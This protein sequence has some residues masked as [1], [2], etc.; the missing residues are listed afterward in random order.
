M[1]GPLILM[2]TICVT[3]AILMQAHPDRVMRTVGTTA[4][5]VTIV[6]PLALELLGILPSSY[7]FEGGKLVTLPQLNELPELPTYAFLAV[8]NLGAALAPALFVSRLRAELERSQERELVR[9]WRFRRL[10]EE[11]IR[12][13][14]R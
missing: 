9:A 7:L 12:A 4:G 2:P 1:F 10:P 8:A 5:A 14:P 13:S 6:A 3:L 11:L